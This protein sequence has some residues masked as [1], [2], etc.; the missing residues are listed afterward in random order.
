MFQTQL[1]HS[2]YGSLNPHKSSFCHCHSPTLCLNP[3]YKY[4]LAHSQQG[5]EF[6]QQ[7]QIIKKT[8][9]KPEAN[10]TLHHKTTSKPNRPASYKTGLNQ[11]PTHT[12]THNLH[13]SVIQTTNPSKVVF[14]LSLD[15]GRFIPLF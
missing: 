13:K 15:L 3:F 11:I 14:F 7:F 2:L 1:I 10:T 4:K 9:P 8:N 5:G 12:H 6:D